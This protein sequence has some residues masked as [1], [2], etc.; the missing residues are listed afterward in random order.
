MVDRSRGHIG[1]SKDVPRIFSKD[2]D[3]VKQ[4][5]E[6]TVFISHIH[7]VMLMC[8]TKYT[9]LPN[10][11]PLFKNMYSTIHGQATPSQIK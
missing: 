1:R 9:I 11:Q 7:V 8:T 5:A 4:Q 10:I 2:K 6:Q 3:A